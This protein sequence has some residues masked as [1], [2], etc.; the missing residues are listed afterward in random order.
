VTRHDTSWLPFGA[1]KDDEVVGHFFVAQLNKSGLDR[2][3][4]EV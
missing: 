1:D 3:V 4:V 2:L